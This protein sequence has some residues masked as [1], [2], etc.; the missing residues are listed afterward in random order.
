[1]LLLLPRR[2]QQDTGD[3]QQQRGDSQ[4]KD[5]EPARSMSSRV[6]RSLRLLAAL[7]VANLRLGHGTRRGGGSRTCAS[8]RQ[9]AYTLDEGGR[10]LAARK[11]RPL[12]LPKLLRYASFGVRSSVDYDRQ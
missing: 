3:N 2:Y 6:G 5:A 11:A 4:F 10:R 1:M 8:R 12:H 9:S 7:G